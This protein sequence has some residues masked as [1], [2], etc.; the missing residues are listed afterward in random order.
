MRTKLGQNFLINKSI[1][2]Q[3]A[4][5]ADLSSK[6]NVLE[7]G[8]GKGILTKYLT[9]YAKK[10]L[11]VEIDRGLAKELSGK[12]R[13]EIKIIEGDV[14]KINLPKL[15]KENNFEN[16]K[17]VA[18][19]PYY[20]TSKI[21]RLFLE[22]KYP[23]SV[24]VLMV[25][26]EVGERIIAKDGKE[27]I[28]SISVK[29]YADPELSFEVPRENF[30]PAPEVDSAVIKITRKN[31][32]PGIYPVKSREAGAPPAQ[33]NRA[34]FQFKKLPFKDNYFDVIFSIAVFHHF[35]SEEYAIDV[36][37]EL[38]RV[39]KPDGK[40]VITVWNLW[41]KQYLKYHKK[42][43]KEWLEAEIPFKAGNKIFNRYH[44]PFKMGELKA[45]FREAGFK[46]LKTKEG[47]NLVY[48]GR[49]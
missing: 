27:S 35:P 4:E 44:H 8:P 33:F 43:K 1:A 24:M 16:Y 26:K 22:T 31:S 47:W 18:N 40:I 19:L 10:V 11:A 38:R 17:V 45:L 3:I 14:L 49:K 5:S 25:Q 28:L 42:S 37:K 23:P 2:E 41:Q 21:I 39:L 46:A 13:K 12:I 7:I 34:S 9:K 29:F 32:I 36:I 15:V 6:D 48:I 20:I 30:D